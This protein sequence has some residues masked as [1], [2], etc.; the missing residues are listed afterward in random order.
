MAQTLANAPTESPQAHRP[1]SRGPSS[2]PVLLVKL[3]CLGIVIAVAIA[4]TPALVGE[5]R[6]GFLTSLWVLTLVI[7][8]TYITRGA[9]P[10]KYLVPG[11]LIMLALVVYPAISTVQLSTTNFGDG[12]RTTQEETVAQ[13]V[14]SSVVQSPEAP[15]Y[16]LTVGTTGSPTQGPFAFLLVEPESGDAFVGTA[17]GLEPLDDATVEDGFVTEAPGYT[18]LTPGQVNDAAAELAEFTVPTEDGAIRQLG[19]RQAFEGTTTLQYD[20]ASET[21]TNTATGVV[22]TVQQQGD[23]EFFVDE[24]GNRLSDQSWGASV[25]LQNYVRA[26]TDATIRADFLR[27]LVWTVVFAVLSVA[28]TFALGLMLA[29]VLNDPRVRFQ[30]LYRSLLLLPY[31]IPGFIG[32]LIW[33]GFFNREFGLINQL[34]GLDINWLGQPTMAKIAV[35]LTNLWLGFP[36]MFLVATGALQAIPGDLKEAASMDGATGF[37]NFRKITLPLL[38]VTTAPLLVATFAFNFNN[39]NVI[40][41]LTEGGPFSPDNPAAGGTDILI[42]YTMRLAFG[43]GGAQFG[44]ASAIATLLFV[45]TGVLA[46]IQFRMTR[47]LE[48]VN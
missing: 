19:I 43:A 40:F 31:A 11:T 35:L 39:Y 33:S 41:L 16:N 36:Y 26:F 32:L 17:D 23:R 29:I 48:D 34:T 2:V 22:Y 13:I 44:F 20:E 18:T 25:G 45:L 5:Q 46:A 30:K 6:W 1:R 8:A 28:L 14:G 21:I 10:A 12:T 37:T 3:L 47:S 7:V 38:I 42:S 9:L 27:I 4:L 24:D 15:R